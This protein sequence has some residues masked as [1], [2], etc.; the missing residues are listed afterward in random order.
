MKLRIRLTDIGL[1]STVVD[2]DTGREFG[3]LTAV[4]IRAAIGEPTTVTLTMLAEVE[5]E[6]E[7]TVQVEHREKQP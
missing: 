5:A 1:G 2:A 6:A 3:N 4:E 7:A